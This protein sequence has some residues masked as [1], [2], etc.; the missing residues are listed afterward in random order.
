MAKIFEGI[1]LLPGIEIRWYQWKNKRHYYIV[2]H[3]LFWYWSSLKDFEWNKEGGE[4]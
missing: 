2:F 4:K 1:S 3:W